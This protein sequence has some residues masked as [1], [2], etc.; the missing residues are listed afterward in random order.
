MINHTIEVESKPVQAEQN[1]PDDISIIIKPKI[2]QAEA[3]K[4]RKPE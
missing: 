1:F 4:K 3:W 2:K